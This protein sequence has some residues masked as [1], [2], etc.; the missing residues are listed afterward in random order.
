MSAPQ[1]LSGFTKTAADLAAIANSSYED[2]LAAINLFAEET[3]ANPLRGTGMKEANALNK[4]WLHAAANRLSQLSTESATAPA[5]S[6]L[7]STESVTA[8]AC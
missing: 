3:R 8:P 4:D 1:P 5:S 2:I 7:L 6:S